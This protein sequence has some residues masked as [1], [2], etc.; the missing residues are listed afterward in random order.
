MSQQ[1]FDR[2]VYLTVGLPGELGRELHGFDIE[3]QTKATSK[4]FPNKAKI[5]VY[6]LSRDTA[7]LF[8][9]QKN[10]VRLFAG[11]GGEVS[12][13]FSGQVLPKKSGS[14]FSGPDYVTV[15]EAGAGQGAY[16]SARISKSWSKKVKFKDIARE[17]AKSFGSKNVPI[18]DELANFE[19]PDGFHAAGKSSDIMESVAR[20]MG[21]DW[22][23]D[24]DDELR[25][26]PKGKDTG[27]T[28]VL[29]SADTGL[30]ETPEKSKKGISVVSLLN[31]RIKP[32]RIVQIDTRDVKGWYMALKVEH[33]GTSGHKKDYFTKFEAKKIEES[34]RAA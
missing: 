6:N 14:K 24:G 4:P 15:I 8:T 20:S 30:I 18:P 31:P 25:I 3:F 12:E 32:R 23:F 11:Y 27:E 29:L 2:T 34:R 22:W 33:K 16:Q 21:F 26:L 28:A 10:S 1:F 19:F 17:L 9:N 5:V 13:L 7:N